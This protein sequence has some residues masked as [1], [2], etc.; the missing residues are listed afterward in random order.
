M[1]GR[2]LGPLL[3]CSALALAPGGAVA[4]AVL[5]NAPTASRRSAGRGS[6]SSS[7]ARRRPGS[8]SRSAP[9]ARGR[10]SGRP[11]GP[12]ASR[13]AR[14]SARVRYAELGFAEVVESL[15]VDL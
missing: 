1:S 10:D 11:P 5:V 8:A 3:P 7:A 2:L 15:S 9:G 14:E 12:S 6:P 4:G 13:Y